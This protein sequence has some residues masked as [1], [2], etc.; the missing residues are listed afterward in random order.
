MN[1]IHVLPSEIANKIAAGEVIERPASV[2]KELLENAVDAG[3]AQVIVEIKKGGVSYIRVTDDGC[4]IAPADMKTAFLRH[5]TSKIAGEDDLFSIRTLGFRGEAL[6]SIAAVSKVEVLSRTADMEAGTYLELHGGVVVKE[7]PVGCPVGTTIVVKELFYN[8]PARMKFLKKDATEAGYA[9]DLVQRLVLANPSVSVRYICDEKEKL[10]TS[11]DGELK[12]CIYSVY[13]RDYA[14]GCLP[15]SSDGQGIR[16]SGFVGNR[17]LSR[18]NRGFQSL[19]VNGRYVKH[20]GITFAAEHAYKNNIMIGKFPFFVLFVSL[21]YD[22]VD[23]NVHP[24]KQEVKFADERR[25]TDQVYW[26][27]KAALQKDADVIRDSISSVKTGYF[28]PEVAPKRFDQTAIV[29]SERRESAP[30]TA[31]ER[32]RLRPQLRELAQE[33]AQ[34]ILLREP[35][36]QE[37]GAQPPLLW[38]PEPQ[39]QAKYKIVGQ[40]FDTYIVIELPDAIV[41]ID[42]HAAHERMIYERLCKMQAEKQTAYQLLL[43]PV[44]ITL[45]PQEFAA[46]LEKT[47]LLEQYGFVIEEFGRNTILV[48]QVPVQLGEDGIRDVLLEILRSGGTEYASEALH[49][50]AC[51]AA[52]KGRMHLTDREIGALIEELLQTGG[53]NSCPHGRPIMIRMTKYELEKM[54]K[55]VQ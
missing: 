15:V 37:E 12:S 43:S 55:R 29:L 53:I 25:V 42:Q 54:F 32:A 6:A 26:A 1:K 52:V 30:Y 45:T 9:T 16:V 50:I 38:E 11:G 8:T 35:K 4:G 14:K 51:K 36:L 20:K 46:A 23:I 28:T 22:Q 5:A 7:E 18:G 3:A 13:G 17:E 48:R 10:F 44:A 2:V 34:P 19:F 21:P 47:A 24:A 27:V 39:E 33:R 31:E 49:T 41:L 40:L